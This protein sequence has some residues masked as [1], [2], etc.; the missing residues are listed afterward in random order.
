MASAGGYS[1]AYDE[2][3][4]CVVAT[5]TEHFNLASMAA[6]YYQDLRAFMESHSCERVLVDARARAAPRLPR[7]AES[8]LRVVERSQEWG[9]SRR[10]RRALLVTERSSYQ[11]WE[12]V[13]TTRGY[14]VRVFTDEAAAVAWLGG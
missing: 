9:V 1:F 4:G 12:D 10:W 13:M 7:D 2:E 11:F 5:F 3:R 8:V 14:V 6:D